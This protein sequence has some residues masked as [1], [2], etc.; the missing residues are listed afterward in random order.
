LTVSVNH[1]NGQCE[2]REGQFAVDV[3]KNLRLVFR[4]ADS[5]PATKPDGGLDWTAVKAITILEVTDY[6]GD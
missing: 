5:P 1:R 2:D 4:S 6:H 3:T